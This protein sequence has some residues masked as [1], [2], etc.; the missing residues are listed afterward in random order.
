MVNEGL[1]MHDY[2]NKRTKFI[3]IYNEE[4]KYDFGHLKSHRTTNGL[5]AAKRIL[6]LL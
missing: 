1:M 4:I 6:S 2:L 3:E 5:I